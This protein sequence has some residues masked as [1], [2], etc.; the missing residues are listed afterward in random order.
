MHA[1][2][3]SRLDTADAPALH[4]GL[5]HRR[6]R[7]PSASPRAPPAVCLVAPAQCTSATH[8][9]L[10][11]VITLQ[12]GYRACCACMGHRSLQTSLIAGP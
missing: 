4:R 8:S 6:P 9:P 3:Q 1:L 7:D 2:L 5:R 10:S 12:Q 11:M